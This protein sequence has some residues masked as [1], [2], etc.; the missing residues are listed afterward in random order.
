MDG[1]CDAIDQAVGYADGVDGEDTDLETF[2]SSHLSQVGAVEQAMLIELVLDVRERE[3][4]APDRN[5]QLREDP[6]QGSDMI[7]VTV[8]EDDSSD[9]LTIFDEIGNVGYN[10]IDAQ[11]FGFGEH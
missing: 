11:E 1:E 7:F 3:L 5:V 9:A 2:S 6:R 10:D 4:G 8:G